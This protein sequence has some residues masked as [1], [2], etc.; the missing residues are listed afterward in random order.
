VESNPII[1]IVGLSKNFGGTAA[2]D[3]VTLQ[4]QPG[5]NICVIGPNSAGK[6]T[7]LL[8][9]G[10][11]HYPT[12][13]HVTVMD[14]HRW[15]QNFEIRERSTFLTA[16]V[17]VGACPTPYEFLR[18]YAQIYHMP[19]A[20]FLEKGGRLCEELN[21]IEHI[22]KPWNEL[23]LG[24]IKKVG[25]V[26]A[27]LPEVDLRILDE[28][29][30]GGIDPRGMETLYKWMGAA[31]KREETVIFSTQVLEQAEAIADRLLILEKGKMTALDTPAALIAKAGI[32]SD[33]NRALHKAFL[34]L[35][36]NE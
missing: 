15:K 26:S 34:N 30:A 8:L 2:I 25:I 9:I 6:T 17:I 35:T 12:R 5:E 21:L 1:D 27:F 28:P 29:F 31:K 24:M 20:E 32:A 19:K 36:G 14:M 33:E 4:I 10:G 18:F 13:G 16:D 3:G 11:V 22:D 23:S 7:L